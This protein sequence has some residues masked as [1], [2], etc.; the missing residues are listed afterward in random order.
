MRFR[1]VV[2]SPGTFLQIVQS[3]SRLAKRCILHFDTDKAALIC[4]DETEGG[5]QVWSC[6]LAAAA[7]LEE[8]LL[9][10]LHRSS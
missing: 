9:A 1:A 7:R 6:V 4:A 8:A 5:V 10:D 2:T 3:I